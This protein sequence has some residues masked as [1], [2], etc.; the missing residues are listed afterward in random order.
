M[1]FLA[2]NF[3]IHTH[4]CSWLFGQW[5]ISNPDEVRGYECSTLRF[6]KVELVLF[7]LLMLEMSLMRMLLCVM[8]IEKRLKQ[9]VVSSSYMDS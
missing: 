3:T 5:T 1:D 4:S 8:S 7:R 2:F 6:T 9:L